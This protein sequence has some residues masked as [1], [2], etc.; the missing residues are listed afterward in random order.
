ML[1]STSLALWLEVDRDRRHKQYPSPDQGP[2]TG[3]RR[4]RTRVSPPSGNMIRSNATQYS[5]DYAPSMEEGV[6]K[7]QPKRKCQGSVMYGCL[8]IE[9]LHFMASSLES[10]NIRQLPVLNKIETSHNN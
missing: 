9:K 7:I 4:Y 3:S 8:Q 10:F 5:Y 2:A 1:A 6:K